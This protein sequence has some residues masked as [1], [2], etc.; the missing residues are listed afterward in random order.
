MEINQY[1]I[2]WVNLDPVIGKEMKK[3]RPCVII[4]PNEMNL[5]LGTVIIAPLTSTIRNYPTRIKVVLNNKQGMIALD[6]IKTIDKIRLKNKMGQ[7]SAVSISLVKQV[8]EEM[9][10]K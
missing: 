1:E 8:I 9:L 3:T 5:H 2:Y 4:S 10:V 6:Q 7:L